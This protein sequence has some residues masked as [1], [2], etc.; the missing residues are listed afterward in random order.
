MDVPV[1][2]ILF[3]RPDTTARVL[4][5]IAK[6]KP[7]KLFV[8]GDGPRPHRPHDIAKCAAARAVVKRL[9]WECQLSTNFLE[10]NLGCGRGPTEAISW[11]FQHTDRAIILEDDCVPHPSFFRFCEEML[12]KYQRDQRVMHVAGYNF[13]L[14]EK[15]TDYSYFFSC[16]NLCAGGW[17][18]WRR[19]WRYHD[20]AVSHWPELKETSWLSDIVQNPYAKE[21][22]ERMFDLADACKGNVDFWDYQW[23]FACWAQSGLSILPNAT[24]LSNIG[25][26][27]PDATH[28]TWA[29]EP[30][31]VVSSMQM[32]P[33]S[34]PLRHPEYVTKSGAADR[35]V[36]ERVIVPNLLG[37]RKNA[38]LLSRFR[39]IDE[40][41]RE[42]PSL[43]SPRKF[44]QRLK[45]KLLSLS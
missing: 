8:F 31:G 20:L 3:N 19:A 23:T 42:H 44:G 17:A 12:E 7:S 15:R 9:D 27:H 34:F 39:V 32:E 35:F 22:W 28:T 40:F 1:L 11:V 13:Q 14:G 2:L 21:Y 25:Y 16:H 41:I 5:E 6:A 18:T 26:G 37:S 29:D 36:V 10:T 33:M 4:A 43:T 30:L 45:E 38:T 24:L